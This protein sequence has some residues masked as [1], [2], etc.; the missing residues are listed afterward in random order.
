M[1]LGFRVMES[2]VE[3]TPAWPGLAFQ[4]I[5]DKMT[6]GRCCKTGEGYWQVSWYVCYWLVVN[7]PLVLL[8]F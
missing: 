8:C 3:I 2:T 6:F 7:N 5:R 1:N 4:S